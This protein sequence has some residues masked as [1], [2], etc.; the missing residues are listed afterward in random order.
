[1][2]HILAEAR[3][4][5]APVRHPLKAHDFLVVAA[6]V[7][8]HREHRDLVMRYRPQHARRIREIAV[9]LQR[10][11]PHGPTCETEPPCVDWRAGNGRYCDMTNAYDV[12]S[13]IEATIM[14][15]KGKA[16]ETLQLQWPHL[17][18]HFPEIRDC[19]PAT[20]NVQLNMAL[21]VMNP[22]GTAPPTAWHP[23]VPNLT[24]GFSFRRI[25]FEFPIDT[26]PTEAWIYIPQLSSN[27]YNLLYAEILTKKIEGIRRGLRCR[28]HLAS[29][30]GFI[31]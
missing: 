24:E 21:L 30:A 22:D 14:R 9:G 7:V 12:T 23:E 6:V 2:A 29:I 19:H 1:L 17:I 11:D 16:A 13:E 5:I 18:K 4:P 28:L 10:P 25:G 31:V 20:I 3:H 27:R 26:P 15:G 8:H